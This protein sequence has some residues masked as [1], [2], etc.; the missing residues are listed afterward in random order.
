MRKALFSVAAVALLVSGSALA[1]DKGGSTTIGG[2]E[3]AAVTIATKP[4]GG[5]AYGMAGCG[6]GSLVFGANLPVLA[7]TLNATG[8]QTFGITSGT[9]NCRDN[10]SNTA[11]AKAFVETNRVAL[12]RDIARGSG[13][14]IDN[15]AAISGCADAKA[16]GAKLQRNYSKLFPR[17]VAADTQVSEAVITTLK[18]DQ[19]LACG[20]L[21]SL[22][23][24]STPLLRRA[25]SFALT[26]ARFCVSLALRSLRSLSRRR[27]DMRAHKS[28]LP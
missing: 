28:R 20:A 3:T 14:T 8:I 19:T 16:V 21:S 9:S 26:L 24:K 4:A 15:L 23:I 2:K 7:A 17:Q 5:P 13:E 22:T 6:L 12:S 25:R 18:S 1:D 11:G 10:A 27:F